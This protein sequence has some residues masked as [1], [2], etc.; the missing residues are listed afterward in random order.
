MDRTKI[1]FIVVFI[2]MIIFLLVMVNFSQELISDKREPRLIIIEMTAE[3]FQFKPVNILI[4][5][6]DTLRLELTTLDVTHG[7]QLEEYNI[8]NKPIVQGQTTIIEFVAN[9]KGEFEFYCTIFCGSG[10]PNHIGNLIV[11]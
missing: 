10:H 4:N 8:L 2:L 9:I 11:K 6:G 3:Q 1:I 7:F 5:I